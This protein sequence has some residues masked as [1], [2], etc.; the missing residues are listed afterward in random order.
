MK[1]N[2]IAICKRLDPQRAKVRAKVK[3]RV[4]VLFW[5]PAPQAFD[6][7]GSTSMTASV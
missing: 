3:V 2:L 4:K 5:A 7:C 6:I 1:Q